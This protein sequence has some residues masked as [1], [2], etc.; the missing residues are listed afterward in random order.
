MGNTSQGNHNS[1]KA[2][3]ITAWIIC[4]LM[5]IIQMSCDTSA[6]EESKP[7]PKT[8]YSVEQIKEIAYGKSM[9]EITNELGEPYNTEYGD[10]M[11]MHHYLGITINPATNKPYHTTSLSLVHNE[12]VNV[13]IHFLGLDDDGDK[14][15][16]IDYDPTAFSATRVKSMVELIAGTWNCKSKNPNG[17]TTS[18]RHIYE[19]DN[20]LSIVSEDSGVINGTHNLD[21]DNTFFFNVTYIEDMRKVGMS[22][23]VNKTL[24]IQISTLTPDQLI[25]TTNYQGSA[26]KLSCVR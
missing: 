18:E 5:V 9:S 13:I 23:Y 11:I 26:R 22:P 1:N 17:L 12:V 24:K 8:L 7:E 25:M 2:P 15:T 3:R 6:P 14:S 4:T 21:K 19:A 20:E 10:G 16:M